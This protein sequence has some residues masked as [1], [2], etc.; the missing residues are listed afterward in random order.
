MNPRSIASCFPGQIE[1]LLVN[2]HH[3]QE[4]V[5]FVR[6]RAAIEAISVL[7]NPDAWE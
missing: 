4:P 3:H 1:H 2:Y 6:L 5:D 7:I